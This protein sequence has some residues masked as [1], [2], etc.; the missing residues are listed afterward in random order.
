MNI[1]QITLTGETN[2]TATIYRGTS[3]EEVQSTDIYI[4]MEIRDPEG[5]L[6]NMHLVSPDDRDDQF[7][8]G[9]T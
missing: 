6:V 9:A 7:S 2:Y 1:K 4:I 3:P 8:A 5:E